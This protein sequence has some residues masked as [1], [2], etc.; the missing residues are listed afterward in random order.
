MPHLH[1]SLRQLHAESGALNNM[2]YHI[3][4][5][6]KEYV[7]KFS[8]YCL[9]TG[10]NWIFL[11][12]MP[13]ETNSCVPSD[14]VEGKK[15]GFC[16]M[17]TMQAHISEVFEKSGDTITPVEV[18]TVLKCE[19][20]CRRC[21]FSENRS[22]NQTRADAINQPLTCFAFR[23]TVIANHFHFGRQEDA[24]E[25]L[26]CTLEAMQESCLAESK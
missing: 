7:F 6:S 11:R 13:T 10:C 15:P 22:V 18:L 4:S 24:H 12:R 20:H 9:T 17:C 23:L 3:S 25:F 8:I 19:F 26:Q 1:P 21:S 14:H 2:W 16:M 5:Y